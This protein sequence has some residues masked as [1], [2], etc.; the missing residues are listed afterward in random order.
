MSISSFQF[1]VGFD[2]QD[3]KEMVKMDVNVFIQTY[4]PH[5]YHY[6]LKPLQMMVLLCLLHSDIDLC[7]QWLTILVLLYVRLS[8]VC[9]L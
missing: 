2:L 6:S 7:S 3:T 1:V 4:Q 5:T 9:R 8:L